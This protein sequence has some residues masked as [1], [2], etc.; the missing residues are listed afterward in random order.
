M[1]VKIAGVVSLDEIKFGPIIYKGRLEQSIIKLAG[2]GY[3]GI[4]IS[5]RDPDQVEV[6]SL[7]RWLK[8]NN[9]A[10]ASIATGPSALMDGLNFTDGDSRT[11][12]G[13]NQAASKGRCTGI[14]VCCGLTRAYRD[15]ISNL[16]YF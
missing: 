3:D 8:E 7:Q 10:L 14:C 16:R 2:L 6:D 4:E 15:R 13:T 9:I 5:L 1:D 11:G 12:S